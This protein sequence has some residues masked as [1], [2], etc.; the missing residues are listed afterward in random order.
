MSGEAP[1]AR[2]SRARRLWRWLSTPHARYSLGALVGAGFVGG[3]VFWVG[4]NTTLEQ[5]NR[6]EF[7]ISCHEMKNTVYAEY[8][9]SPHYRNPSGVRAVCS[10]CHVPRD[11]LHK[12]ARKTQA[13]GEVYAKLVGRID[14]PEKFEARRMTLAMNEWARLKANDS[15]EC[16]NCHAFETM[17]PEK[18]KAAA[19]REHARAQK[20][21]KTCIDCHKGIAHLL[22]KEYVEEEE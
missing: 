12:L 19:R 22:P 3:I 11:F 14:T 4:F 17:I 18:Q 6:L 8:I 13:L 1:R 2:G 9:E 20:E 16:R 5:T 21:G 7:C 15:R 10:D